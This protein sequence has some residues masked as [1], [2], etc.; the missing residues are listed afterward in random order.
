[1]HITHTE[2]AS[3]RRPHVVI[4]GDGSGGRATAEGLDADVDV[5]G[6]RLRGSL[7]WVGWLMLHVT[8][9]RG[10]RDR[11]SVMLRSASTTRDLSFRTLTTRA[12]ARSLPDDRNGFRPVIHA[13]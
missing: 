13:A 1:V 6:F 2:V 8:T 11:A 12:R 9:P 7:G 5:R 10:L 3:I 4:F